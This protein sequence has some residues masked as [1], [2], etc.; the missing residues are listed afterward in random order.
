[1]KTQMRRWIRKQMFMKRLI[2][3]MYD[4]LVMNTDRM[5]EVD[6]VEGSNSAEE[7][8][9]T[10]M[11]ERTKSAVEV[12][13]AEGTNSAV[14]KWWEVWSGLKVLMKMSMLRKL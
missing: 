13:S 11:V 2:V 14:K 1:M 8:E 6:S 12:E 5:E 9:R 7:V 10:K 4:E 3:Q